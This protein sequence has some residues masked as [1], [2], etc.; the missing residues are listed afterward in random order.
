MKKK[1]QLTLN[2]C[3]YY[4][5]EYHSR[6]LYF[7]LDGKK[8]LHSLPNGILVLILLICLPLFNAKFKLRMPNVTRNINSFFSFLQAYFWGKCGIFIQ[9][10]PI[11]TL[12]YTP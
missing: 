1:K 6:K 4:R 2:N 9:S 8:L 5:L 3:I 7:S 11:G 10:F 12:C